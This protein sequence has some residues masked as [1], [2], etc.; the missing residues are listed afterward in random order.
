MREKER[1]RGV[2]EKDKRDSGWIEE[3]DIDER[4]GWYK[5]RERDKK[6]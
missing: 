6:R 3:K 2:G 4:Q 1:D 5:E